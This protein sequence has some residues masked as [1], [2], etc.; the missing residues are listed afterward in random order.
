MVKG[1]GQKTWS[2]DM[3]KSHGQRTW[4][5]NMG[6]R[7][8]APLCLLAMFR[9]LEVCTR[10]QTF[11]RS[12]KSPLGISEDGKSGPETLTATGVAH[13]CNPYTRSLTRAEPIHQELAP[14]LQNSAN[15]CQLDSA[16]KRTSLS[17]LGIP[18]LHIAEQTGH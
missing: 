2:K 8:M 13:P 9:G 17:W 11:T 16:T 5:K 18:L 12:A 1:H 14:D 6:K 3:I 10:S 7:Q 15:P 4:S